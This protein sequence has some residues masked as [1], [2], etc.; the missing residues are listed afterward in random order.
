MPLTC[1]QKILIGYI[2]II[3]ENADKLGIVNEDT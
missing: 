2:E 3:Q 1:S